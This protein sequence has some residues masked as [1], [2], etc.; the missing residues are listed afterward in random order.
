[1]TVTFKDELG[2][3]SIYNIVEIQFDGEKGYFTDAGGSDFTVKVEHLIS[4]V[5]EN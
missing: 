1:M 5:K 3:V 2:V 4:I